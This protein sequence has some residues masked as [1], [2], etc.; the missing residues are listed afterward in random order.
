[1]DTRTEEIILQER[2]DTVNMRELIGRYLSRW[3]IF[4]V[5]AFITLCLS[6]VYLKYVRPVYQVRTKVLIKESK[7]FDDPTAVLF[8]NRFM[9]RL[10]NIANQTTI[11][12]SYPI[13]YK[14]IERANFNVKYLEGGTFGDIELYKN[15][16]FRV[17][18]RDSINNSSNALDVDFWVSWVSE[19]SFELTSDLEG[20]EP[21]VIDFDSWF[22]LEGMQLKINALKH[23]SASFQ[24][25]D[26]KD[27]YGFSI[28][29]TASLARDY[30]RGVKITEPESSSIV[31]ISY[32]SANPQKAKD[33]LNILLQVFIEEDLAQKNMVVDSTVKFIDRELSAITDSLY[34]QEN[35]LESFQSSLKVPNLSMQGEMIL[36]EFSELEA[37]KDEVELK[38]KYYRYISQRLDNG[39]VYDNMLTPAAFG[40]ND[41][42]LNEMVLSFIG[43]HL[44]KSSLVEA[45]V[46]KG[47]RM[48][49]IDVQI[50]D[51]E[52]IINK[53]LA[54]LEASNQI[55]LNDIDEKIKVVQRS[56]QKL[57]K[58]EREYV[59]LK[60]LLN[61]N[62][63]IY[64]F[65]MEKRANAL[66]TKSANTP[67]AR[68]IEPPLTEPD[69]PVAPDR[70][71]TLIIGFL[72]GLIIPLFLMV[73]TDAVNDK[74][75]SQE[76]LEG[77]TSAP[78]LG[79]IPRFNKIVD[80]I[81]AVDFPK[82]ALAEAMRMIRS[83]LDFYGSNA[84]GG[85][86]VL[87]TSSISAEGKTFTAINLAGILALSGKK[88]VIAGLD[89]RKPR[90]HKYLN[91]PN[92]IGVSNYL[93][94]SCEL[95]QVVQPYSTPNLDVL[96][97]GPTPPN[98]AE[99]LLN[100][101]TKELIAKLRKDYDY[102]ILDTAPRNLV[103]DAEVLMK[104]ADINIM[105]VR[106]GRSTRDFV[107]MI[108]KTYRSG[109][110]K[111]LGLI[112]NDV[113]PDKGYGYGYG[114][115]YYDDTKAQRPWNKIVAKLRRT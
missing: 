58:S 97:S 72:M 25:A 96:V 92:D 23:H 81:E 43:L 24:R 3:P 32:R 77:M 29:T 51:F 98:P 108:D 5:S 94:G 102:V 53:S 30:K 57:P 47:S 61:I 54:D 28:S 85:K 114:D 113:R 91:L 68:I 14:A 69:R 19:E 109:K 95:S 110:F 70:R 63:G 45:G 13:V 115:G 100:K 62:E 86:V 41:P 12:T 50:K 21:R 18:I 84:K 76:E 87:I 111:S 31:D 55:V 20:F 4:I 78:I 48:T 103:T 67:D 33:F 88:T 107:K 42:V 40:I 90:L 17:V 10:S 52:K 35:Q 101:N 112:M 34:L 93:S 27:N 66:I 38:Q 74:I 99:L 7:G 60:R 39:N 89:L 80:G 2:D 26:A 22:D 82:S 9:R 56:A 46:E 59:N 75:K 105:V 8:G 37:R 1:M 71:M 64:I 65:L 36:K 106:R 11:L 104:E 49:E 79:A 6:M 44:E 15:S 16:P 73:T 83:N